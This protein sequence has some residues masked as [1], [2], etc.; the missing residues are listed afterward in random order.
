MQ[1]LSGSLDTEAWLLKIHR[2]NCIYN[3]RLTGAVLL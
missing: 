2:D 1:V 3:G